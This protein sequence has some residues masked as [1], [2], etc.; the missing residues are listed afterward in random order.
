MNFIKLFRSPGG[1]R[2]VALG[3]AI[4]F[5]LEML[6]IST[7]CLIY[8]LLYPLVRLARASLPAAIIGN[9]IG[10]LSFLPVLLIPFAKKLGAFVYPI[11]NGNDNVQKHSLLDILE[12]DFSVIK[13]LLHGGMHILIGMTVF[14]LILGCISYY[15]VSYL[16][17]KER[18]RRKA[19]RSNK[20]KKNI[21][22]D[23]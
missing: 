14:G 13:D 4:G 18:E 21:S 10:K 19:K 1:A 7:A 15:I 5:G 3:F 23:S 16:Y 8:I 6:V 12:G 9:V 11:N 17:N 22:M 20:G 2:K